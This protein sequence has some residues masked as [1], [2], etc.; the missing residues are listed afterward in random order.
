MSDF[1]DRRGEGGIAGPAFLDGLERPAGARF[2]EDLEQEPGHDASTS[3]L[4]AEGV[5]L[6]ACIEIGP[7]HHDGDGR[8]HT[9]VY[10]PIAWQVGAGLDA[11]GTPAAAG[12]VA[13]FQAGGEPIRTTLGR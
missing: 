13:R 4:A 7:R 8:L 6:G 10:Q 12:R 11:V 3:D 1:G 9:F 2:E 5:G